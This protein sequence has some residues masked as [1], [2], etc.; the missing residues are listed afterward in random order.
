MT[1]VKNLQLKLV[2]FSQYVIVKL[3]NGFKQVTLQGGRFDIRIL[4]SV[5]VLQLLNRFYRKYCCEFHFVRVSVMKIL[6]Y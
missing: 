3:M 4:T 1:R 6:L 5:S 2:V